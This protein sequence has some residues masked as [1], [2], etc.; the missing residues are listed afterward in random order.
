MICNGNNNGNNTHN[1]S[2]NIVIRIVDNNM[3][4]S[5]KLHVK[6]GAEESIVNTP[7]DSLQ[8]KNTNNAKSEVK[9]KRQIRDL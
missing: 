9:F 3:G 6:F 7:L 4:C 5:F 8:S 1:N 2:N